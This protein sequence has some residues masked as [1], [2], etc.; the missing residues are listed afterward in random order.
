MNAMTETHLAAVHTKRGDGVARHDWPRVVAADRW[1]RHKPM[2][3]LYIAAIPSGLSA[4]E[5]SLDR[6]LKI[7]VRP[8]SCLHGRAKRV[9]KRTPCEHI[10]W[11]SLE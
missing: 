1:G 9:R 11:A 5:A 2:L 6:A 4:H 7:H 10:V 8:V 3:P